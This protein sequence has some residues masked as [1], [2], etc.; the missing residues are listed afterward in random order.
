M[1]MAL[2]I[3]ALAGASLAGCSPLPA[4][5]DLNTSSARF[6]ANRHNMRVQAVPTGVVSPGVPY[7]SGAVQEAAYDRYQTGTVIPPNAVATTSNT[8]NTSP[9]PPPPPAP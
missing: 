3:T 2:I 7:T 6:S 8:A 9:A 1:K 5:R 4:D